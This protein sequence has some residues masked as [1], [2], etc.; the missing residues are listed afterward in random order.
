M[1]FF[2]AIVFFSLA[3][4]LEMLTFPL[5]EQF[6]G[7]AFLPQGLTTII[8]PLICGFIGWVVGDLL[9]RKKRGSPKH[10]FKRLSSRAQLYLAAIVF[11][12]T[13]VL[14]YLFLNKSLIMQASTLQYL[15]FMLLILFPPLMLVGMYLLVLMFKKTG[16]FKRNRFKESLLYLKE[17][18]N[19][20]PVFLQ[21]MASLSLLTT[22]IAL[23][24]NYQK[25]IS[26][27]IFVSASISAWDAYKKQEFNFSTIFILIACLYNPVYPIKVSN[28]IWIILNMMV[29]FLFAYKIALIWIVEQNLEKNLKRIAKKIDVVL[30][31]LDK[32][33]N[34]YNPEMLGKYLKHKYAYALT[35]KGSTIE[36]KEKFLPHFSF[37]VIEVF[38]DQSAIR[39]S[40]KDAFSGFHALLLFY[41]KNFKYMIFL[42]LNATATAKRLKKILTEDFGYFEYNRTLPSRF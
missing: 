6:L 36:W 39:V 3:L 14:F 25:F 16:Y 7:K 42:E 15:A 13:I 38:N 1:R 24:T 33:T 17:N 35:I 9:I 20:F 29:S 19:T 26:L 21:M 2:L 28:Q 41:N 12:E 31:D 8:L 37:S 22:L 18:L 27:F 32:N 11:W 4:F 5:L 10:R 30:K 40:G 34:Q 23:D